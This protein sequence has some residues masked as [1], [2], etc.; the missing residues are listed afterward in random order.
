LAI[1]TAIFKNLVTEVFYNAEV[2][3]N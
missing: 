3:T 2:G 1:T